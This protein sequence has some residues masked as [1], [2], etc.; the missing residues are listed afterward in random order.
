MKGFRVVTCPWNTPRVAEAQY[1]LM[2]SLKKNSSPVISNNLIGM[3]QTIWNESNQFVEFCL[4][5]EP[6]EGEQARQI[7][8]YRALFR[9]INGW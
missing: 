2:M 7:N 3:V 8:T 6:G 5:N 1:D 9:K 4:T